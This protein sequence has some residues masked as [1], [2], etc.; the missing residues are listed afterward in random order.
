MISPK[1]GEKAVLYEYDKEAKNW[2]L[3]NDDASTSSALNTTTSAS[4]VDKLA[5]MFTSLSKEI[6][7]IKEQL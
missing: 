7:S 2:K 1:D 6:A 4:S 5:E 3:V